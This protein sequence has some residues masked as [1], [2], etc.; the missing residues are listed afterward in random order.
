MF[1]KPENGG[2]GDGVID[3]H[4][5]IFA[6]LQLW[7]DKNHNG[8]SE[9]EELFSLP[10]LGVESIDL[11]YQEVSFTDAFGNRFRFRAKVDDAAHTHVGRWAY[12]VFLVSQ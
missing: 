2:N 11:R 8:I 10:A 3:K 1:D 5:A 9:P 4:D 12:D 6:K 7:Q